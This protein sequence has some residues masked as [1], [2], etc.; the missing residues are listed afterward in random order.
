MQHTDLDLQGELYKMDA[1]CGCKEDIISESLRAIMPIP[2][3]KKKKEL[4]RLRT[5]KEVVL[6]GHARQRGSL[7]I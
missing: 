7:P 3:G 6:F 4:H 1:I 2:V 5:D